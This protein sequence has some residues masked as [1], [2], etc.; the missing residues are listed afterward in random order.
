MEKLF[1][2]TKAKIFENIPVF[3]TFLLFSI[4]FYN[5]LRQ[6]KIAIV[7]HRNSKKKTLR[8]SPFSILCSQS[9]QTNEKSIEQ[10][11]QHTKTGRRAKNLICRQLNI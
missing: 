10:N 5:F 7:K 2:G 4:D 6:Q 11:A 8:T 3:E 9:F 1:R